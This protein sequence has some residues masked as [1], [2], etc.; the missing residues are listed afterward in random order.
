MPAIRDGRNYQAVWGVD[1]GEL[2][3]CYWYSAM[4]S[5]LPFVQTVDLIHI[6]YIA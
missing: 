5:P 3:G 1:V 6:T 4:V 2:G